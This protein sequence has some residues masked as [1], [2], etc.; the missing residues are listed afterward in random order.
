MHKYRLT[1]NLL[2]ELCRKEKRKNFILRHQKSCNKLKKMEN[3][4]KLFPVQVLDYIPPLFWGNST[5][6]SLINP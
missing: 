5:A 1:W 4:Y 2:K 6:F 3:F